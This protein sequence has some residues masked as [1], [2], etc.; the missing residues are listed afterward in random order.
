MSHFSKKL[1]IHS[2]W[3]YYFVVKK[4][5]LWIKR[6]WIR[7]LLWTKQ[8]SGLPTAA[9][10]LSAGAQ[11]CPLSRMCEWCLHPLRSPALK[12]FLCKIELWLMSGWL[13]IYFPY[14]W[15]SVVYFPPTP[16]HKLHAGKDS[17]SSTSA[18]LGNDSDTISSTMSWAK[19]AGN[20]QGSSGDRSR[21]EL[22]AGEH[23]QTQKSGLSPIPSPCWALQML[24]EKKCLAT[25]ATGA[26]CQ[27]F[28][29]LALTQDVWLHLCA[30][31]CKQ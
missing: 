30:S 9:G 5:V 19:V 21:L 31:Y 26:K 6:Y 1:L 3:H 22:S 4:T 13:K 7:L 16:G 29:S 15:K 8:K 27:L 25:K 10:G 23:T 28:P 11:K 12:S 2:Q 14:L 20:C 24:F 18:L 17:S